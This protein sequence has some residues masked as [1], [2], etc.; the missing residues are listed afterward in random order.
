[1]AHVLMLSHTESFSNA[2]IITIQHNSGRAVWIQVLVDAETRQ[3]LIDRVEIDPSDPLNR[4]IVY[5]KNVV[6]GNIQVL[7][8]SL[9]PASLP[10]P[11][12][13]AAITQ[14]AEE[15]G[16]DIG[17]TNPFATKAYVDSKTTNQF[18]IKPV[19]DRITDPPEAPQDGDRYLIDGAGTGDWNGHG[20]EIAEY[21]SASGAWLYMEPLDGSTVT[22]QDED[23]PY[24]QTSASSPW[25][26]VGSSGSTS[27][28]GN[29]KH[30]PSLLTVGGNRSDDNIN[31]LLGGDNADSLHSHSSSNI[32][33]KTLFYFFDDFAGDKYNNRVWRVTKTSGSSC[34]VYNNMIGGQLRIRTDS[35]RTV[36]LN[37]GG[38]CCLKEQDSEI[39]WRV[40]REDD[41]SFLEVGMKSCDGEIKFEA[42]G[43]GVNWY[44]VTYDYGRTVTNTNI[45][46]D[47]NFHEFKIILD[48]NE[49]RFYVD[50]TLKAT[51]STQIPNGPFEPYIYQRGY[52]ENQDTFIDYCQIKSG[53]A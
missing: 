32:D 37:W 2:D 17:V 11:I 27:I 43:D 24:T 10:S 29:E 7:Y 30:N 20:G 34:D 47:N 51:H 23:T 15:L 48:T 39:V 38:N 6:S 5:L 33:R 42:D 35:C 8:N 3:D 16:T 50:D 1:M 44:A 41:N 46:A 52:N 36:N 4:C 53:R 12:E 25:N 28:H 31:L 21:V 9:V 40:R 18:W 19:S 26:W 14:A 45:S 49:V 13:S 22:V